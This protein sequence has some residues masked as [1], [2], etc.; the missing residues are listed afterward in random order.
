MDSK[1]GWINGD[2][3][4]NE[5]SE[6]EIREII[7]SYKRKKEFVLIKDKLINLHDEEISSLVEINDLLKDSKGK[8]KEDLPFWTTFMLIYLLP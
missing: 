3:S 5:F 8:K 4:S 7:E 6:E 1:D 2:I